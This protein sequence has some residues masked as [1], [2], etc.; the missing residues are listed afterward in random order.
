MSRFTRRSSQAFIRSLALNLV[1]GRAG[2]I[3]YLL[4]QRVAAYFIQNAVSEYERHRQALLSNIP[5][6]PQSQVQA[7]EPKGKECS[8]LM[9]LLSELYNFQVISSVL[10]FD[11]V[12]Q[13]LQDDLTEFDVE[14]LLKLMCSACIN[15][16]M[17]N[18][19]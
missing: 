2:I 1:R 17:N 3:V 10:V 9:I 5:A 4:I 14:L 8:N 15:V 7:Q 19:S 13:L 12:H 11:L 6:H 18:H 16:L